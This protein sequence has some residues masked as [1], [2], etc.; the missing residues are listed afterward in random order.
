MLKHSMAGRA[1]WFFNLSRTAHLP[2]CTGVGQPMG[3]Q[4]GGAHPVKARGSACLASAA[5]SPFLLQEGVAQTTAPALV[6]LAQGGY[7]QDYTR[8]P[9][10]SG[11]GTYNSNK[12]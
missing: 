1:V 4:S 9:Q 10:K 8:R 11:P 6:S 7:I 5:A 2:F 12:S 3:G